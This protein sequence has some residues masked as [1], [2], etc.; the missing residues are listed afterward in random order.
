M[1]QEPPRLRRLGVTYSIQPSWGNQLQL[2]RTDSTGG[3]EERILKQRDRKEGSS[4]FYPSHRPVRKKRRLV[5]CL[6][7]VLVSLG[8][9][10]APVQRSVFVSFCGTCC[11]NRRSRR[12]NP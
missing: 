9:L 11:L 4:G 8:P 7:Q 1:P 2:G 10:R 5:Q 3:R 12:K 6:D